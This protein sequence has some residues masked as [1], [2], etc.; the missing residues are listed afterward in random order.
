MRGLITALLICLASS[1]PAQLLTTGYGSGN[2]A[3]GLFIALSN[4]SILEMSSNG[5]TLGTA[6]IAG[7]STTGVP[8]WALTDPLG[9]FQINS[10]TGVVTV[11][12]NV[13]LV[14]ATHPIIPIT[15]SVTGTVP[16]VPSRIVNINV[17]PIGCTGALD[18]SK[19]CPQ[20]MLGGVP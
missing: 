1:A 18:L 9:V 20:A 11:L 5:T 2:F 10:S 12:S 6:S 4:T 7:G 13:N 3:S 19:G 14:F 17:L 8:V 16:T 15:I